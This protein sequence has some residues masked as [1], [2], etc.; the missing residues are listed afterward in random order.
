M[1]Y[2]AGVTESEFIRNKILAD[3]VL[4]QFTVIGEA[5]IYIDT[6]IL[7]RY[8]YPWY[9]VR[10]FR[11]LISHQYFNVKKEAVWKIIT[12]ELP[13]LKNQIEKILVTDFK[14]EI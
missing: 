9:K 13:E 11:N 2:S 14:E 6:E 7:A 10:A 5:L 3:A 12:D 1:K 4:F 8:D